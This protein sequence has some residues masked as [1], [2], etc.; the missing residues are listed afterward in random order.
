M[1]LL[2][3]LAISRTVQ[4]RGLGTT[5]VGDA[6]KRALGLQESRISRGPGVSQVRGPSATLRTPWVSTPWYIFGPANSYALHSKVF[7]CRTRT[8]L[9]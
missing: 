8:G 5:L 9:R 2:G 6:L 3:R 4:S 7:S 1:A